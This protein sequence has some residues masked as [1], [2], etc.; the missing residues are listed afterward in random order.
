LWATFTA[1][2]S[3]TTRYEAS[4]SVTLLAP[5]VEPVDPTLDPAD[6]P[7]IDNPYV[8]LG[9]DFAILVSL[10]EEAFVGNDVAFT[11]R[12]EHGFDDDYDWEVLGRESSPI[13]SITVEAPSEDAALDGAQSVREVLDEVVADQQLAAGVAANE[14][15]T[16]QT[17]SDARFAL[18]VAGSRMQIAIGLGV[19]SLMLAVGI[20]YLI[21]GIIV[22][23]QQ[24]PNPELAST[25]P[26]TTPPRSPRGRSTGT[27]AAVRR[28]AARRQP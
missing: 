8:N 28:R 27:D 14:R 26:R 15:I 12:R 20:T 23:R 11:L 16:T 3:I 25:E 10:V 24:G 22:A 2:S 13:V 6:V 17:L 19:F 9:G 18:P 5:R 4:S 1:I 7:L 21:D